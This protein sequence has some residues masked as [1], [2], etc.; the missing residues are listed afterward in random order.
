MNT[1]TINVLLGLFLFLFVAIFLQTKE[2]FIKGVSDSCSEW[3]RTNDDGSKKRKKKKDICKKRAYCQFTE[4]SGMCQETEQYKD[5]HDEID[6]IE[7]AKI[8]E[9]EKNL[10]EDGISYDLSQFVCSG[11]LTMN[12]EEGLSC[13]EFAITDKQN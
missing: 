2:G 7:D 5:I 9:A 10:K 11:G 13:S 6:R 8:E 3:S 12:S 1:K 4:G